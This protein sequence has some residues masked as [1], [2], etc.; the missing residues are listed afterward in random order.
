MMVKVFGWQNKMASYSKAHHTNKITFFYY[1]ATVQC[2]VQH[3]I[4]LCH[5]CKNHG[6]Q[7]T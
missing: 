7:V 5:K 4:R 2:Y 1:M 6:H 3:K